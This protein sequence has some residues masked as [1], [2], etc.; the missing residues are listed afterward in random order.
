MPVHAFE[1]YLADALNIELLRADASFKGRLSFA[2]TAAGPV[3]KVSGDTMVEDFRAN[4]LA[5]TAG[6]GPLAV[7]EELLSWSC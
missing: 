6:A 3:V 4:T 2:Q 1:P 7:G 5:Q